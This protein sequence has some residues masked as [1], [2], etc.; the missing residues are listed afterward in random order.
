MHDSIVLFL[1]G[2]VL[3]GLYATEDGWLQS[4]ANLNAPTRKANF[5]LLPPCQCKPSDPSYC[6][7]IDKWFMNNG[8]EDSLKM[9]YESAFTIEAAFGFAA[10]TQANAAQLVPNTKGGESTRVGMSMAPAIWLTNFALL[11]TLNPKVAAKMPAYWTPIPENVAD[12]LERSPQG[13]VRFSRFV[14]DFQN[15]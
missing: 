7:Y 10:Q 3:H 14:S 2:R 4:L 6:G 11:Y 8:A 15:E 9:L 1:E 13:R 12:A 5:L